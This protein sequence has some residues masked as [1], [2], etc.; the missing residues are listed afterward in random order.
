[1]LIFLFLLVDFFLPRFLYNFII[2]I[3]NWLL[4]LCVLFLL[5]NL[6]FIF[7][8]T[9]K[10]LFLYTFLYNFF[11]Y[12]FFLLKTVILRS[13]PILFPVTF[14]ISSECHS[15]IQMILLALKGFL[16]FST[17][18]FLWVRLIFIIFYFFKYWLFNFRGFNLYPRIFQFTNFEMLRLNTLLINSIGL[19]R[20][21]TVRF[22]R[23]ITKLNI[24][25]KLVQSNFKEAFRLLTGL[26]IW[27]LLVSRVGFLLINHIKI[28][29]LF[30]SLNLIPP[31]FF[32]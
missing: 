27:T 15:Q 5:D 20:N 6:L 26:T 30:T 10:Y 22:F 28:I 3:Y 18:L 23:F 2:K 13:I 4:L 19:L 31:S 25:I 29:L 11:H 9:V 17:K 7:V 12:I 32:Q 8:G 14:F 21:G 16:F 1:M 24:H